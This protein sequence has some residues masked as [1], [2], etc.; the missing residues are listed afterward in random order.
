MKNQDYHNKQDLRQGEEGWPTGW[1]L[2]WMILGA[3]AV[4]GLMWVHLWLGL[5]LPL[6]FVPLR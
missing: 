3:L 1:G 4:A 6:V 5:G 2:V